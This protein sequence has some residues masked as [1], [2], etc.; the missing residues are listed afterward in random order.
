MKSK[1]RWHE[2]RNVPGIYQQKNNDNAETNFQA[3]RPLYHQT[4]EYLAGM[5]GRGKGGGG[6]KAETRQQQRNRNKQ[7]SVSFVPFGVGPLGE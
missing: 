7:Q 2:R 1:S 3:S 5:D 6:A 4:L